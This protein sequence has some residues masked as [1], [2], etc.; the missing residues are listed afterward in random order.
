MMGFKK[1]QNMSTKITKYLYRKFF[2][3]NK[4]LFYHNLVHIVIK[5]KIVYR[6]IY[7]NL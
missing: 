4:I 6:I 1:L 2:M 5:I 3:F 7:V